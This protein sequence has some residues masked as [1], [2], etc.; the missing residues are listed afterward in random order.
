MEKPKATA[1][2]A[3]NAEGHEEKLHGPGKIPEG[4]ASRLP[5]TPKMPST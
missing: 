4:R 3:E 5:Y 1:E 2:V